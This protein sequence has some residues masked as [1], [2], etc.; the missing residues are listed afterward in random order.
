MSLVAI[1]DTTKIYYELYGKGHPVIFIAGYACDNTVWNLVSKNLIDNFTVITLDNLGVGQTIDSGESFTLENI[2]DNI[3]TFID[4]FQLHRPHIIGQSMGGCIAQIIAKKYADKINKLILLNTVTKF[5]KS[6][7]IMME[8][9]LNLRREKISTEI[10]F[11]IGLPWSF[12]GSYLENPENIEAH[13]IRLS[14]NKFPQSTENQSRQ[15]Q[16][17]KIFDSNSWAHEITNPTLIIAS[18]NDL[19]TPVQ[20]VTA[21]KNKIKKAQFSIISGGHA[22]ILENHYEVTKLIRSFL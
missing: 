7:I 19:I 10:L 8:A 15:L 4:Y 21:L 22:S 17:L 6:S 3:V 18:E 14:S 9:R 20:D 1:N 2:A 11:N 12:S 13:K 5:N 16:A